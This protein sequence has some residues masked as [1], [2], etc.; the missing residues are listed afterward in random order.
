MVFAG[1]TL[2]AD[3]LLEIELCSVR[4]EMLMSIYRSTKF[5]AVLACCVGFGWGADSASAQQTGSIRAQAVVN[6]TFDEPSGDALDTGGAG[7]QADVGKLKNGPQRAAS[8]FWGQSGKRAFIFDAGRKQS[9][10]FS[11][12]VDLDQPNAVTLGF[13]FLNLHPVS[14]K[15]AHGIVAKRTDPR[16]KAVTNYGI[17]YV[18]SGDVFQ[19]YV[20]DGGGF[21]IGS[22]SFKQAVGFRRMGYLTATFEVGD[23]PAPDGDA[24]KDDVR[25]RLFVNGVQLKPVRPKGVQIV[26]NDVWATNLQVAGLLNNAPLSLGST[27]AALEHTSGLIDEFSLIPRALSSQEVSALFLEVA[28]PQGAELAKQEAQAPTQ[29]SKPR[30]TDVSLRGLQVGGV[31]RL[32]VTGSGLAS[33]PRLHLPFANWKQTVVK[34][35]AANRLVVDVALP[36]GTPAGYYPLR[37]QTSGGLSNAVAM[38][39]DN[40]KQ[41]PAA[42]SSAA[43]PITL[44]AAFSGSISG[45][46]LARVYFR[47]KKGQRIVADVETRRLGSTCDPV[48]EVK[49]ARGTPLAIEWGKLHVRGDTRAEL[50]LPADGLYFVEF[51]DLSYKAPGR[52]PFRLKI[53]D[54]KVVD[55][56]F[57]SI[58]SPGQAVNVQPVGSGIPN[59]TS[60]ATTLTGMASGMSKSIALPVGLGPAGAAPPIRV[61]DG[62]EV[63]EQR[64]GA[65]PQ[66]VKALFAKSKHVPVT[67]NGRIQQ[68]G[69]NDVYLLDVTPGQRLEFTLATRAINSPLN[70]SLVVSRDPKGPALGQS[71]GTPD[72]PN[73]RLLITV[74]A[75]QKRLR[76][77]IRDLN[78]RGAANFLYRLQIVPPGRPS[79]SLA[80]S[81][82]QLDLPRNGTALT[83]LQI[84]RSGYNGAIDLRVEGDENVTIL[85]AQLPAGGG[86]RT[87]FVTLTRNGGQADSGLQMLRVVGTSV[88]LD[89]PLRRTALTTAEP[90]SAAVAGYRDQLAAVLTDSVEFDF[91]IANLPPALF[92][93]VTSDVALTVRRGKAASDRSVR[94]SIVTTETPRPVDPKDAKKGTK[95]LVRTQSGQSLDGSVTVGSLQITVPSDVAT[96]S[97]DVVIKGEIVPHPYS[98]RVLGVVY[99]KPFQIAVQ[100]PVVVKPDPK[101]LNVVAETAN[102]VKG[103]IQWANGFAQPLELRVVGLKRG[104]NAPPV[105]VKPGSKTFEIIFNA[106]KEAEARS[107]QRITLE[108]RRAK[109]GVL[110]QTMPLNVRVI[111]KKPAAK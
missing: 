106:A 43:N 65:E 79:F 70:G 103:S 54:I 87:T 95:P 37:V 18:P 19:V 26:G 27:S 49:T 12:G 36:P 24:D 85:P 15:V 75:G 110:L 104:H 60:V 69:E 2:N 100:A 5:M 61:G 98:N 13:Y 9:I 94:L 30:I 108:V 58:V 102:K 109:G 40:L 21:R 80:L 47:G 107:L 57:P 68:P 77:T 51:H 46:S 64:K 44:P 93:G 101:S 88:G 52:S 78:D 35:S 96:K 7:K 89:P 39:V 74:P 86:N 33:Q 82:S 38:A 111:L 11:D 34:G 6:L 31:T 56:F 84:T 20:N 50:A 55:A 45:A 90:G 25:M 22:F 71:D 14:D 8:P 99:S 83:R 62:V 67:I 72:N 66:V 17:N 63:V 16:T 92:K 1:F 73:P 10:E 81:G 91:N 3:M 76:V 97:L 59:G 4:W 105:T 32:V 29:T 42:G 48:V 28:G 23:A 41:L 53:G